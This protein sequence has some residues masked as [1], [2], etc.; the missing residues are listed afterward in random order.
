MGARLECARHHEA[1]S[2]HR[3]QTDASPAVAAKRAHI[4]GF[5]VPEQLT[6]IEGDAL[7]N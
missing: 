4:R 1:L 6:Q 7:A 2:L 5:L 3:V